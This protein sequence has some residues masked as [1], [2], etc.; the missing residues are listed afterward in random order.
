MKSLL[1][2]KLRVILFLLVINAAVVFVAKTGF[3]RVHWLWIA[4][5]ALSINFLLLT[6]D[7]ILKF[8]D[9]EG[10]PVLGND[11]WGLLK[12]VHELARKHDLPAPKVFLVA[13]ESAQI[14][15]YAKSRFQGRLYI[16]Q[17]ALRLLKPDEL[18]AALAYQLTVLEYSYS[19][20][21]YWIGALIDI[22]LR[23][24]RGIENLFALVF[25][26][27]PKL[28][29]LLVSPWIWLLQLLLLSSKDFRKLDSRAVL[30][31]AHPD[32]L[33]RALWKMESYAQTKPWRE[34]WVFAHMCMVSPL[35]MSLGLRTLRI[36]P[37]LKGRIKGLT[38]QYPI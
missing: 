4:P 36:Q 33:V 12:L 26:W 18:E 21:N 37:A 14:F 38:G 27:S 6:Y 13:N 9:L 1:N 32:S 25:G 17:G 8:S 19:I 15:C 3:E 22:F 2:P 29:A 23:V 24:G 30:K 16:T 7:Q 5:I 20:L 11:P 34:A 35:G 28:S 31:L 10:E